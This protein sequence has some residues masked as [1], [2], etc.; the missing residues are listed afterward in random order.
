MKIKQATNCNCIKT[1]HYIAVL[2][3]LFSFP[4]FAALTTASNKK[5]EESA[6]SALDTVCRSTPQS[7]DQFMNDF[8]LLKP[9]K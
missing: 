2:I 8:T 3:L 6:E 9:G 7:Y 5:F 1:L 4:V